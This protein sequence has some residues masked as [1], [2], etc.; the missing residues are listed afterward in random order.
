MVKYYIKYNLY[1][2]DLI[3][4][5]GITLLELLVV[6]VLIGI[7]ASIA[8]VSLGNVIENTKENSF[9]CLLQMQ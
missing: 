8:F 2:G 4:H 5:N 6:I 9:F 1:R 7:I 3:K